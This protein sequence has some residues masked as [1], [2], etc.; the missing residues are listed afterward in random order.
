[1]T[2]ISEISNIA[3]EIKDDSLF[4][5]ET[6]AGLSEQ[7]T[8]LLLKDYIFSTG[9]PVP[10][11]TTQADAFELIAYDNVVDVVAANSGVRLKSLSKNYRARIRNTTGNDLKVYPKVGGAI[12]GLA[13]DAPFVIEGYNTFE[14]IVYTTGTARYF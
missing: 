2:K 10:A 6:A 13:I 9:T 12:S 1:M 4:E 11:G 7:N 3:T 5:S 8:F 14:F